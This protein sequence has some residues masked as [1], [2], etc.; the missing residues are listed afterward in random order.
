MCSQPL[1]V[2]EIV[3]SPAHHHHHR[4]AHP[5]HVAHRNPHDR[6]VS[7]ILLIGLTLVAAILLL[8]QV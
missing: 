8:S 1:L 2:G 4:Q 7:I 5:A 6:A 3:L